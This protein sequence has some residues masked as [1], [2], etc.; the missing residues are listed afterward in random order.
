M[1]LNNMSNK[2]EYNQKAVGHVVRVVEPKKEPWT[3]EIIE[4]IDEDYFKIR[5]DLGIEHK[6]DIF[7]VRSL[8]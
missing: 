1:I 4:A 6:V 5:D 8:D 3:G 7:N 2:L